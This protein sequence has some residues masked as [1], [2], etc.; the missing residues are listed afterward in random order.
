MIVLDTNVI[1]EI[2]KPVPSSRVLAWLNRQAEELLFLTAISV[3]EL[4]E[5]LA[6][7]PDG[8]RRDALS[9]GINSA[10]DGFANRVLPFDRAAGYKFAE[11]VMKAKAKRYTLPVADGYIAAIAA[12]Y[13]FIV[14]T[15]DIEPFLAAGV[16][17][18]NPW[19]E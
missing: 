13:G 17:V 14:A 16:P 3:A 6:R 18:I 7:L 15:R 1:S 4:Q 12:I 19:E 2:S 8:K 9:A 11:L 10:I 5:G